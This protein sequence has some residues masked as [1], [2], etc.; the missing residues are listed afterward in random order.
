MKLNN[1]EQITKKF[2]TDGWSENT[3]FT[4]LSLEEAKQNGYTFAINGI[5]K[6]IKYFKM[7]VTGNI[8]NDKGE[9]VYFNIPVCK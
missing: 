4:E 2:I 8:F 7:S 3:S 5:I 1:V 6:G 9:V